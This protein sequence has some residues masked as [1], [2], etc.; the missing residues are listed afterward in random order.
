MGVWVHNT[1]VHR[2]L[3]EEI[4][5]SI[6]HGVGIALAIAGLVFLVIYAAGSGDPWKIVSCSIYGAT[7]VILYTSSTLYHSFQQPR[8]KR[9]LQILDHGCIY[10]LIA[11]TYTPFTL[12]TL[13]GPWGWSLFGVIWTL[14]LCG[15]VFKLLFIDRFRVFSVVVYL[16]MGW[17]AVIAIKPM[18]ERMSVPA[19]LWIVAGGLLY[20]VGVLFYVGER[21]WRYSHAVWHVFVLGGSACHYIAV[22]LCVLM[23]AVHAR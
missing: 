3:R 6:T 2:T 12:V 22:V 17:L 9:R 1:T 19:L 18:M 4:A 5:N 15:L 21:R 7:L 10:L 23:T 20:T 8:L 11:G 13:R 14:A 16:L